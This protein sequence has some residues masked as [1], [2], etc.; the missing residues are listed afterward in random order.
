MKAHD[1]LIRG[2]GSLSYAHTRLYGAQVLHDGSH[3]NHRGQSANDHDVRQPQ[4]PYRHTSGQQGLSQSICGIF[5]RFYRHVDH[6]CSTRT[7]RLDPIHDDMATTGED[8]Q[9]G[10][11][12][13]GKIIIRNDLQLYGERALLGVQ[14]SERVQQCVQHGEQVGRQ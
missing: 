10:A 13:S 4:P 11:Q 5:L 3:P 12:D 8:T 1:D 9:H 2:V 6:E 7:W 14:H